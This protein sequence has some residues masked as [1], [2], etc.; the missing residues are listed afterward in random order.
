MAGRS[1]VPLGLSSEV[2]RLPDGC[3]KVVGLLVGW[4]VL[5]GENW[6]DFGIQIAQIDGERKSARGRC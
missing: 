2:G 5:I 4:G 6:G 1:T 3:W